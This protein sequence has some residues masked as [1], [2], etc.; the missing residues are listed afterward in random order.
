MNKFLFLQEGKVQQSQREVQLWIKEV[1]KLV[2]TDKYPSAEVILLFITHPKKV[3]K[4]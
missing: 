1:K 2:S 4:C 3:K